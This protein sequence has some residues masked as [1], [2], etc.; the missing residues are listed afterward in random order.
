MNKL[1]DEKFI[2]EILKKHGFRFSKSMGQNFLIDETVPERIAEFADLNDSTGVLEIGPGIGALT[3]ELCRRANRVVAVELD[4]S[5]PPLLEA[6]LLEY[7]NFT[8][9]QGDI[10]KED[11][12]ALVDEYFSTLR[13]TVCANL[14][15]NI[16]SPVLS[17]L[18]KADVFE[19]IVIMVQR[20]VAYRICAKAGNKNYGSLSIFV[21]YYYTSE[22]LFEV[23]P[24]AFIPMP[25]VYSAVIKLK[26]RAE[27]PQ[28]LVGESELFNIVRGAFTQRR[29]ILV[30]SLQ[31]SLKGKL[32]KDELTEIVTGA[33][34]SPTVRAEE[35]NINEFAQIAQEISLKL[36]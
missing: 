9:V 32:S 15:Y 18:I 2:R 4:P 10:L 13:P 19:T 30:N 24:Q 21:N 29:K 35:L 16:T 25:S 33:G 22:I 12:P 28:N 1:C 17:A 7:N 3:S 31:A 23:P 11:I 36:Q 14:P 8:L 26:K 20:E 5:L 6:T 34:F 27:R